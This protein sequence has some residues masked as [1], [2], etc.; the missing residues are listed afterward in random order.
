M[1]DRFKQIRSSTVIPTELEYDAQ[2][3][4]PED[5]RRMLMM[6]SCVI[7]EIKTKLE[8][9]N[10]ELN[11]VNKRN[12]IEFIETR[13]KTPAS[14]TSKLIRRGFDVS[15]DSARK[16]LNDIA[17]V[18]VICSFVDDIYDILNMLRKQDDVKILKVKDYI[19]NPKP[20]GYR[21]LHL[22]VEIPVFFSSHKKNLR[23]EV[24]IRTIA[25]DFW[26]SLEHDLHYKKDIPDAERVQ[27]EL[28]ECAETIARTDLRMQEIRKDIEA[29]DRRS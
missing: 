5:I 29:A 14:I 15:I 3:G 22:I 28:R 25:M 4:D 16:N 18:R 27:Q 2:L 24:Q 19:E 26:A 11:V 17:G 13:V 10:E 6:Y 21:S 9:L 8:V 1:D 12:P 23:A 20:N 7:R